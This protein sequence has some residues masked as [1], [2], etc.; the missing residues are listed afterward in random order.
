MTKEM[1]EILARIAQLKAEARSLMGE[2]KLDEAEA[3]TAEI[4]ELNRRLELLKSLEDDDADAG[5]QVGKRDRSAEELEQEYRSVFL[6]G[7]RRQRVTAEERSIV[8]EYRAMHTGAVTDDED[9]DSSLIVP[10][11]VQTTINELMR[12][13]ND[14]S[15]YISSESVRTLT[16]SR[17]LEKDSSLTP[18]ATVTELGTIG[19]TDNPQF[20][21]VNYALV[22]RA[23][24]LPISNDLLKATDQAL[25]RYVTRWIAKKHVVTKNT[26]IAAVL[27]TMSKQDVADFKGIK[28]LLNTMLDPAIAQ[29]ATWLTNQDGFNWLDEQEDQ[30][31]RPLLQM[32]PTQPTRRLLLGR[33]VIVVANRFL[34]ST[35]GS[36]AKAPLIVGNLEELAIHFHLG[37]YELM[38]TNIGGDAFKRDSTDLRVI[39]YDD[40]KLWDTSAAVF[41]QLSLS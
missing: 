4:R 16:G 39:T 31:G 23:G 24:I 37:R 34:P 17:V 1:R 5:I 6:K 27:D 18:F 3:K 19:E 11:D 29:T 8:A 14:L 38:A 20:V 7:L 15:Q 36:P 41:G 33:P 32:D 22:K 35:T 12:S 10:E 13:M 21:G 30:N 28:K 40:A 2:N 25:L 9:G 26:I